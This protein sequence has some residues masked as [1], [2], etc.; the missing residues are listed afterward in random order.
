MIIFAKKKESVAYI[1][2]KPGVTKDSLKLLSLFKFPQKL[3]RSL[4]SILLKYN[5]KIMQAGGGISSRKIALRFAMI[6]LIKK[7]SRE[8]LINNDNYI[9][10]DPRKKERRKFGL[11][12][13]R[14]APQYSKR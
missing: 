11:K 6:K 2:I 14:K 13:A 5:I 12:K 4:S 9:Y 1:Q 3:E 7:L 8:L 10:I